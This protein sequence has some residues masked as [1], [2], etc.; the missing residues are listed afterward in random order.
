MNVGD[1]APNF[2]LKDQDGQ[3]VELASLRGKKVLLS[4]H[5]L[6]W[7][8]VCAKQMLSLEQ[9]FEEFEKFNV[10]PLGLSVDPIPS[11]KAW[12]DNLGISKLKLLSDFWP[13]GNVAKLFG[14]FR[15][16]DG[17]SERANILID[18]KGK[19]VFFKVY[20]IKELPNLDEIFAFLKS[21][22]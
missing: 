13:H 15:E 4:F 1:F 16:K 11:K 20:P 2:S 10:V 21:S 18:E 22:E 12:A 6:A 19:I 8:S 17:F 5:P 14:I 3:V 7:T 9:W